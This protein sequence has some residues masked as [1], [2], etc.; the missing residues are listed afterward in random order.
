MFGYPWDRF[1]ARITVRAGTVRWKVGCGC[2]GNADWRKA[3]NKRNGRENQQGQE[4]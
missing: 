1:G 2:G 4:R 3:R